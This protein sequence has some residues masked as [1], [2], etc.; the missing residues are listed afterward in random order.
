MLGVRVLLNMY[1]ADRYM[2]PADKAQPSFGT[3]GSLIH[4]LL[5]RKVIA[6]YPWRDYC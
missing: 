4:Y 5:Y 2:K 6:E 3:E 1:Y